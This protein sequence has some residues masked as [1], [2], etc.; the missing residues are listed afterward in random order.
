M[1]RALAAGMLSGLTPADLRPS[2]D[3]NRNFKIN[4]LW[5]I[6]V[7]NQGQGQALV[8]SYQFT[9]RITLNEV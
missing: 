6:D 2:A 1:D 9:M 3:I 4:A 8:K 7:Q 5:Q